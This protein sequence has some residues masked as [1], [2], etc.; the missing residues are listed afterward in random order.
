ML[1][2]VRVPGILSYSAGLALQAEACAAVAAGAVDTLLLV[3]V[4]HPRLPLSAAAARG[5]C[6]PLECPTLAQ[7][8]QPP[9]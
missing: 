7:P 1:R 2:V 8:Q 9:P 4:R 6:R 5:S 3:E